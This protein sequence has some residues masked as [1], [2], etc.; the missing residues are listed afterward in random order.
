MP[1]HD[2]HAATRM[3]QLGNGK[4]PYTGAVSI[5]IYHATTYA[6]PAYGESTG[7]D[8]TRSANPTRHVLEEAIADLEGGV[9]GFAFSSGMAA[10]TTIMGLLDVGDHII[11]S[12]DLYGGTHR[13][14]EQVMTRRGITTSYVDASDRRAV[15]SE[16]RPTTRALFIETP[17]NP[18]MK[19]AD[20]AG[21]IQLAKQH[22]LVTI[23]DNTFMTPYFQ[24]PLELGADIVVHSATKYLSGH[25]DVL[26]GLV[27]V[28]EDELATRIAH[29]H[30]AIGAALGPSD[31]WLLLRGMKTLALRMDKHQENALQVAHFLAAH[32]MVTQVYYVGL[33][34]HPGRTIHER[35]SSGYGGMVSFE[36]CSSDYVAPLLSQLDLIT[37]AES[38]GGVE[39]LITFPAKQTHADI[40]EEIRLASGV[41][42]TLLRLSVGVEHVEDILADLQNAFERIMSEGRKCP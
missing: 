5:P 32:P 24:R 42:N 41:T 39:T 21:C 33:P 37:F 36:V 4:D 19:V 6:H 17:T 8:Y 34:D 3:A 13:L 16:L 18:T 14:F 11:A 20:L 7:Y 9:A 10:I 22:R 31:C 12:N 23:V 25:N 15:E 26:A 2:Y 28:R 29:L 38:L 1:N 27:A 35:Q 40:P 30:N